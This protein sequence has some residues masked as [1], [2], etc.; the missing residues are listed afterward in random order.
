MRK[1]ILLLA[2]LVLCTGVVAQAEE[3]QLIE[4]SL[5]SVKI[6]AGLNPDQD[7]FALANYSFLLHILRPITIQGENDVYSLLITLYDFPS[8][9]RHKVDSQSNRDQ[10][11]YDL[12]C[13]YSGLTGAMTRR[14]ARPEGDFRD[15][16]IGSHSRKSYHMATYYNEKR[17]EGYLFELRVKDGALS[18]DAAEALLLEIA[19]SLREVG[20]VY[21][22]YTGKTL[23]VTHAGIN[24][25]S[26]PA[27]DSSVLM[28]A[29]QGDTFPFLG[30]NGIWY[31]IDA[32]GQIG[33][34]SKA[35]TEILE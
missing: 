7:E 5:F 26:G 16:Y 25:R 12:M 10:G 31:M 1:L 21:P 18:A 34:V 4:T 35:L 13:E 29:K 17:G 6:P 14:S 28:V 33:Y 11:L 9:E 32:G 20:E 8:K 30:E 15:F 19:A 24:V 2:V 23:I 3:S 22:E 27:A